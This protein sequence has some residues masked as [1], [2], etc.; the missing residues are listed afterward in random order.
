VAP[1]VVRKGQQVLV[2][3]TDRRIRIDDQTFVYRDMLPMSVQTS[4]H[5]SKTN[6]RT[7]GGTTYHSSTHTGVVGR[8]F[9]FADTHGRRAQLLLSGVGFG[10]QT[11]NSFLGKALLD[12]DAS[13][14]K[15][16]QRAAPP[17]APSAP[18]ETSPL[19]QAAPGA[20]GGVAQIGTELVGPPGSDSADLS[21]LCGDG[22]HEERYTVKRPNGTT[23]CRKCG[24]D[25]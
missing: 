6:Y 22:Q 20:G 14:I 10:N 13:V 17:P 21:P 4:T 16:A 23:H 15:P 9:T 25:F 11:K 12:L 18:P 8:L 2:V 7:P 1:V 3:A 24:A 19:P 5:T